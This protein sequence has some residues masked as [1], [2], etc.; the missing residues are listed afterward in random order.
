[1]PPCFPTHVTCSSLLSQHSLA[2]PTF[3]LRQA[4]IVTGRALPA[5]PET[6]RCPRTRVLP[7]VYKL[8]LGRHPEPL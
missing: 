4:R 7:W 1:M 2:S 8:G 6:F 5:G 3:E